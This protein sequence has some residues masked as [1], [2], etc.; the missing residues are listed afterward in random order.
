MSLTPSPTSLSS[1]PD[2]CAATIDGGLESSADILYASHLV[3]VGRPV[4]MNRAAKSRMIS[5]HSAESCILII[6][7]RIHLGSAAG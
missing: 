7:A 4:Q 6:S 3:L 2:D 1:I 5:S